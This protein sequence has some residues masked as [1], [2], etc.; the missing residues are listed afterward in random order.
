[1]KD[2]N[3]AKTADARIDIRVPSQIK[4]EIVQENDNTIKQ[5]LTNAILSSF[6]NSFI[7]SSPISP[8]WTSISSKIKIIHIGYCL[9]KDLGDILTK[10]NENNKRYNWMGGLDELE[11]RKILSQS[12]VL[13]ITSKN[14]GAGR[15][16]GEAIELEIPII[17]TR[18]SG[19]LGVLGDDY[20]GYYPISNSYLS[21]K[22][23]CIYN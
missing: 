23:E 8:E 16:V 20:K 13:L 17:S 21:R 5:S 1:M 19:V 6:F 18:N 14:E 7:T 22:L 12:N 3:K 10:E 11:T 9:E 2:Y 4:E 15:V